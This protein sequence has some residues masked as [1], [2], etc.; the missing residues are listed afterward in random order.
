MWFPLQT[1]S[2]L[3]L[4]PPKKG[5]LH[6]QRWIFESIKHSLL[7]L[8]RRAEMAHSKPELCPQLW[9]FHQSLPGPSSCTLLIH[10]QLGIQSG[11]KTIFHIFPDIRTELARAALTKNIM[12]SSVATCGQETAFRFLRG[13]FSCHA[14]IIFS[15]V[16]WSTR[17]ASL[18]PTTPKTDSSP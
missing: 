14:G 17:A 16:T 8:W 2:P 12:G 18:P 11:K 5:Q 3:T 7:L 15:W 4:G 6:L 13:S 9:G 1:P 10:I